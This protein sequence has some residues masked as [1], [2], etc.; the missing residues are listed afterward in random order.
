MRI[1]I[2]DDEAMTRTLLAETL[3]EWKY[4][5]VAAVDGD[6]AWAV[7]NQPD[8]PEVAILDWV[9]PGRSG[10]DLCRMVRAKAGGSPTYLILLTFRDGPTDIVAGLRSGANDYLTKPC[11]EDEL[12]ARLNVAAQM[13][14]VQRSLAERVKELENALA[15]IKQLRGLLPMCAW[16][17]KI[18]DDQNYWRQV[19][20]YLGRHTDAHFAHSICPECYDRQ[21]RSVRPVTE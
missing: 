9:M 21:L 12:A 3:T 7:L 20:D 8:P 19:E 14:A 13:I 16:C 11:H 4:E 6:A 10:P 1:L 5:V 18:R 2:A 17:K 15:Q